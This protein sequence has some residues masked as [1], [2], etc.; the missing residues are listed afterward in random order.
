MVCSSGDLDSRKH[1]LPSLAAAGELKWKVFENFVRDQMA[2]TAQGQLDKSTYE[3][4]AGSMVPRQEDV[5]VP[6]R[7]L[8]KALTGEAKSGEKKKKPY[9]MTTQLRSTCAMTSKVT[10]EKTK[11]P[12]MAEQLRTSCE[13]LAERS[14]ALCALWMSATVSLKSGQD[15][16]SQMRDPG[17]R[18]DVASARRWCLCRRQGYQMSSVARA[19]VCRLDD[20]FSS[21]AIHVQ[22]IPKSGCACLSAH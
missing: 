12:V 21:G 18:D 9:E 17:T 8:V 3:S 16:D 15:I 14:A 19:G 7:G 11:G 22:E 6:G 20:S 1:S 2:A 5:K 13:N 10:L 4:L